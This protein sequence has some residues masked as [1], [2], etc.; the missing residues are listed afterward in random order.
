MSS[1][2]GEDALGNYAWHFECD[3]VTMAQFKEVSGMN[4]EVTVI[5][6]QEN[7]MGGIPVLKKYPGAK[8][9]GDITLKRGKTNDDGWWKWI[10]MVQDG[11]I[12]EARRNASIV[13]FD[14]AL[15]E[16]ARWNVTACWISKVS[17]GSLQAGASEMLVEE[18]TLVH[19][20]LEYIKS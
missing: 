11:K 19:E 2:M 15:G 8:K 20:G 3:G 16:K 14:A 6:Q 4:V 9:W 13:L 18:C 10:K 12:T 5:S 1:P 7:K 17:V